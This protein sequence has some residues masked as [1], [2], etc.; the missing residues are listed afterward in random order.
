MV[1]GATAR[2]GPSL[3]AVEPREKAAIGAERDQRVEPAQPRVFLLRAHHEP[4]GEMAVPGRARLEE[5]PG[6]RTRAEAPLERA[7]EGR[8]R[9]RD[10][11]GAGGLLVTLLERGP[12][13]RAQASG[14]LELAVR[15]LKRC[16]YRPSS[17]LFRTPSIHPKQ[18][19]SSRASR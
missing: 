1:A 2:E 5:G 12:T 4:G 9:A 13:R 6:L 18:S 19:A 10:G 11:V 8:V 7:R 15:G 17:T 14:R 16:R 3:L